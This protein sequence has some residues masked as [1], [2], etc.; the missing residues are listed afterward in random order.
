MCVFIAFLLVPV[1][2]C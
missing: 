1:Y 2:L